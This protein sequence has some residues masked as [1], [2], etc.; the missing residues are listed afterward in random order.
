MKRTFQTAVMLTAVLALASAPSA[1]A[2]CTV[3]SQ[4]V[5]H[6]NLGWI[7]NCLDNTPVTGYIYALSSPGTINSGVQGS[8]NVPTN[9]FV[10]SQA[11]QT[12]VT[13][14]PCQPEAGNAGDG[15]VTIYYD[16]GVGNPGSVGCPNP[17]QDLN[18]SFPVA[19]Q[20]S[21]N[22]G[23]SVFAEIGYSQDLLQYVVELAGPADGSPILAGFGNGPVWQSSVA[24]PSPDAAT[25]CV[26]VPNPTISSDCDDTSAG[27]GYSCV[28]GAPGSTRPPVTRGKLYTR[29]APCNSSPDPRLAGT[30]PWV[31]TLVQPD[32]AGHAC[33]VIQTP[34]IAGNCAFLGASSNLGGIET[35]AIVGSLRVPAPGA[36]NDKVKIDNAGF[37]QG[38]LVVA[39]STINETSIVGFNV[40]SGTEKLNGNTITAKG[41]GSNAYSFEIGRGAL[42]GGKSVLVEAVKSDG[43]VEKTAP[44]T[45]K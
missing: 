9:F 33:N 36:A 43:S 7:A 1:W 18:G 12:N 27:F 42:K 17:L 41:A 24:G 31:A 4:P 30:T 8:V 21:C 25:V 39:F 14:N 40:Y 13:L 20:V 15:K 19:L 6:G 44:V 26:N 10:C 5:W 3:D 23:A 29:E 35:A 11:G 32:A 37:A 16:F 45:L 38:K 22:D 28:A 34:T 2:A